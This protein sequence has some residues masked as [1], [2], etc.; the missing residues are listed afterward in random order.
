MEWNQNCHQ[1]QNVFLSLRKVDNFDAYRVAKFISSA[2]PSPAH[3]LSAQTSHLNAPLNLLLIL[4]NSSPL[5]VHQRHTRQVLWG[6]DALS[7]V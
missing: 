7:D 3:P 5:L 4:L 1:I 6:F 2:T